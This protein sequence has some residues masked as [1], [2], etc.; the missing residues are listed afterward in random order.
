MILELWRRFL[1]RQ[2]FTLERWC[3]SKGVS[4]PHLEKGVKI[5]THQKIGILEF[6]H[7]F[8]IMLEE[9]RTIRVCKV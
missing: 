8:L 4:F 6:C 1:V 5:S 9:G 7:V 2:L 3:F